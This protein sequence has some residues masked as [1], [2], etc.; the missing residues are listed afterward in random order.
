MKYFIKSIRSNSN[1]GNFTT[2]NT[3][4]KNINANAPKTDKVIVASKDDIGIRIDVFLT[5]KEDI[6]RSFAQK[7]IEEENIKINGKNVAK[8]YKI[9]AFDEISIT[10]PT[11]IKVEAT[12]QEIPLEIV[13]EDEHLAVVN[14]PKGMVVHPA[15]GNPDNTLVNALLYHMGD[16]L[17]GINGVQR[18]GI[19]HRIDKDT[20]GALVIAKNDITHNGLAAQIKE[21]SFDRIY[22]AVLLGNL[23]DDEGTI[24]APIGRSPKDRKKM[25]V[26]FGGRRA[27]THYRVLERFSG[28][29]YVELK[30]ETGRTHQIRVHMSSIGHPVLGDEVYGGTK[31]KII[32]PLII[33]E[34]QGQCLFAK[35]IGFTHPISGERLYFELPLPEYFSGILTKLR[36]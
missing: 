20:S 36:K 29:C 31:T 34:S 15:A 25:A 21:H 12:A 4:K 11:L 18:P 6:T 17:S 32:S 8:N 16:S 19:V 28:A 24:D 35:T 22:H 30:L 33:K 14:K 10:Y 2:D 26:V 13:F 5:E 23:K 9:R 1:T 27:V 3:K 7:L